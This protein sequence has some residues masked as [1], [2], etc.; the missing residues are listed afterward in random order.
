MKRFGLLGKIFT[1]SYSPQIHKAF[2]DYEYLLYEKEPNEV[3]AFLSANDLDGLNVTIPYKK[4]AFEACD[5]LSEAA[6]KLRN[7]NTIIRT[8]DGRLYGHNTD[9]FGFSYMLKKSGISVKNKKVLVLGSGGA[10]Q[11]VQVVLNDFGAQVVVISRSGKDNYDNLERH[12]DADVIVNTTP[13][14]M[15]PNNGSAPL[16]L[17]LFSKLT[18]V[19]DLIY[20]PSKTTLLIQAEELGIPHI[21][22]LSMLVAQAKES[23]ELFIGSNIDDI[24]IEKTLF[25][26]K[27]KMQNL[28]LIG[29]PGC[30]KST[31]GKLLAQKTGR[32]FFDSDDLVEQNTGHTIPEIFA[33]SGEE[34]FRQYETDALKH[35][36]K[37]SGI[38][39]ATGGG[40]V[41]K[42]RN[43]AVLRQNS[44]VIWLKRDLDALET[45]GRPLSQGGNLQKLY[46][47]RE[48]LY[49][50][51]SDISV[52]LSSFPDETTNK[53]L[54]LCYEHSCH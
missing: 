26:M 47:T 27:F 4:D 43:L 45:T 10:S 32:D 52:T 8:S 17:K 3:K 31:I 18:G 6:L 29:M 22:G 33:E 14:G 2:G 48:P 54:E 41:T 16:D 7:V 5:E 11:T 34:V 39:I 44:T 23:A 38:V 53:I 40:C 15:Y 20:N 30:G 25:E 37:Q 50:R 19:L 42:E 24:K 21:N 13:V 51:F 46:Q 28:V 35:L 49:K 12:F 36:C 9:Y 1:H